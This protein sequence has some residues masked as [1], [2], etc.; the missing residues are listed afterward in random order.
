M[1]ALQARMHEQCILC[2]TGNPQGLRLTFD[3]CPDGHVEAQCPCDRRFQGYTGY[4]HGGVISAILD[5]AMTNCLFAHGCVG[6]TGELK[7]RFLKPVD[8][9]VT[10]MVRA[11]L[12]E[13]HGPLHCLSG[14]LIQAGETRARAT[15][16]FMEVPDAY[17][18]KR[19]A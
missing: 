7:L 12:D 16:K 5:S 3:V 17:V 14:E 6:M 11:R 10:A 19:G 13:S 18:A 8:V 15:A 4:L 1:A 2:R 9:G